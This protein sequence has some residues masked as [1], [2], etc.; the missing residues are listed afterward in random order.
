MRH[1]NEQ[2]LLTFDL[3]GVGSC[4]LP[5][6]PC[7]LRPKGPESW[8]SNGVDG[9][10]FASCPLTGVGKD[11]DGGGIA[12]WGCT[13]S[14]AETLTLPLEGFF[15]DLCLA[16]SPVSSPFRLLRNEEFSEENLGWL[17]NIFLGT[18]SNDLCPSGCNFSRFLL[19]DE[20]KLLCKL[21]E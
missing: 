5:M 6:L 3:L 20:L 15:D 7:K 16:G 18:K 13:R 14:D 12:Y 4:G 11:C 19:L 10:V 9:N 2:H 1:E 8:K 17:G 21:V